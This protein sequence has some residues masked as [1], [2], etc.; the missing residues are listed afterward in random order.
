MKEIAER[1]NSAQSLKIQFAAR[2][3]FNRAEI[4]NYF[5][6]FLLILSSIAGF[7][8]TK[9]PSFIITGIIF[10][11]D[12]A[13]YALMT[14]T[15]KDIQQAANLRNLFDR[16]V[17]G[18]PQALKT[19]DIDELYE[20]AEKL[21]LNHSEK[22]RIQTT[23]NGS[24]TPPGVKDWYNTNIKVPNHIPAIFFLIKENIWWDQKMVDFKIALYSIIIL[25]VGILSVILCYNAN[26]D[27]IFVI[28]LGNSALLLR[29]RNRIAVHLK[30]R[31]LS[32]IIDNYASE[33]NDSATEDD[34]VYLQK[35]IEE[36]RMLEIVHCNLIHSI[37]S[38]S[39]H[40]IYESIHNNRIDSDK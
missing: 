17:F 24:D 19:S 26:L 5:I 40:N 14:K 28:I 2:F 11:I 4:E 25:I 16:Y 15:A 22:Y 3:L 27:T 30:Y 36:R 31:E 1:Q 20:T 13:V 6:W 39:L 38:K 21:K 35:K 29:L 7:S 23:H 10:V 37:Y 8:S 34:I 33:H 9:Y 18:L 12:F 32:V